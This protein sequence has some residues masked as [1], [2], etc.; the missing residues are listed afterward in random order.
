MLPGCRGAAGRDPGIRV[1]VILLLHALAAVEMGDEAALGLAGRAVEAQ[2]RA[3]RPRV[4]PDAPLRRDVR[5]HLVQPDAVAR[6][7]C[8]AVDAAADLVARAERMLQIMPGLAF[9]I[10][11]P[12]DMGSRRLQ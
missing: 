2:V 12:V 1:A 10:A 8:C 4:E 6:V 7:Q 11:E 5:D 3:A 9:H